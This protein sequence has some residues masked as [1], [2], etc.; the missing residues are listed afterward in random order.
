MYEV[1]V[2]ARLGN[3]EEVKNKLKILGCKFSEELHQVD[4]IFTGS[5]VFPPPRGTPVFRIRTQN[6]KYI[7]TL[8]INQ[9]S[10]LDCIEHELEISNPDQMRAIIKLLGYKQDVTVDKKRIKTKYKDME[11]V[12]DNVKDL[13]EFIEAEKMVEH[14]NPEDRKKVQIELFEFLETIGVKKEDQVIDGKYDIMLYEKL[15]MK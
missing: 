12:L 13:G 14:E 3:R 8:K 5:K 10:R 9:S 4:E 15:N 11:I 7:F 2:K 1:E 6:G